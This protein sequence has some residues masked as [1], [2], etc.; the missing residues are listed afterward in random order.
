MGVRERHERQTIRAVGFR[1]Y[2]SPEVMEALEVS[3][4][5]PGPGEVLIRV[6]AAG[7]N[8][9]DW[10]LRGGRLR[11]FVRLKLPFS[12]GSDVA[13]VV[14][15]TGPGVTR[16]VPGEAVFAMTPTSTGGAYAEYVA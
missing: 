8:P 16:F 11:P 1:H 4:P 13:G 7:V 3:R 12:S 5:E 10:A 6:A 2:G 9:A 15:A 14:E